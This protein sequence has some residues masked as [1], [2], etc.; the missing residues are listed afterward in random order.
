VLDIVPGVA[1]H[2]RREPE[3]G[4]ADPSLA[5]AGKGGLGDSEEGR[6]LR[7]GHEFM[8]EDKRRLEIELGSRFRG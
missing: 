8:D 4:W 5:P 1:G 2:S 3:D 7:A 6:Y